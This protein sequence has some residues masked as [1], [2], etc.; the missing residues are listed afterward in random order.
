MLDQ[1]LCEK[2][3]RYITNLG[4][5]SGCPWEEIVPFEPCSTRSEPNP[6]AVDLISNLMKLEAKDRFDVLEA[7]YHPF[8]KQFHST[9]ITEGACPFKVRIRN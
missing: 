9:R 4:S 3:K 1:I 6:E 7:I 2:T 5:C 8:L